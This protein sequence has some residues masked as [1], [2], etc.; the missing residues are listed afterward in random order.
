MNKEVWRRDFDPALDLSSRQRAMM[1][2]KTDREI[3]EI[4]IF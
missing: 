3:D 2:V 4:N 1:N